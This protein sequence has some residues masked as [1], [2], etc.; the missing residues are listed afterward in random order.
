MT[1]DD[2]STETDA[3]NSELIAAIDIGTN[4]VHLVV[5]RT[6]GTSGYE[7]VTTQKEVVRLG[8]GSGDMKLLAPD[9]IDRGIAALSR[10]TDV[11]HSLGATV[12]AVATSAVREA[13][14]RNE[15]LDRARAEAGIEVE[16]ISGFEEARLI[17][18]GILK[19][20]P[21]FD[22]RIM[23]FDI[24]GGSTEIVAGEGSDLLAARSFR[25]GAI[26]L[27]ERF[28][29]DGDGANAEAVERCR[30]FVRQTLAGVRVEFVGH[31]PELLIASSGTAATL[32][33]M[34]AA[35]EALDPA[36]L[37]GATV[38][39]AQLDDLVELIIKTP[40][41][42]RGRIRGLDRKRSDIILGGAI[43][44]QQV[45]ELSGLDGFTYSALALRE[46][47]L[48]D[49]LPGAAADHLHNLRRA[50]VERLAEQLDPD[51]HHAKH[52]TTLALQLFDR[53]QSIHGL[54][55]ADRELLEMAG[56][57]H[58]VGLFI[59]HSGHHKHSYY[60][61]RNSE[62]LTGFSDREI[63]LIAQIARYHRKSHPSSGH[64]P[65]VELSEKDKGR[66]RT[67]AGL[68][69]I[70]I[71]LDRRHVGA[72]GTIR[73]LLG[74]AIEIEPL[75]SSDEVDLSVE[76]HAA[77]ERVSLLAEALQ[78]SVLVSLPSAVAIT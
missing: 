76:V 56:L 74:D 13:T 53:T 7:V 63:G 37:N 34:A 57:L 15:F 12:H 35:Q 8:S 58:N 6:L 59:S 18:L 4:S 19:A 66:V 26:R 68:L 47:V 54:L 2:R 38:T 45:V 49:R 70:A 42:K 21:V 5:A 27:T 65:F 17:H 61:I 22:K 73:V 52:C 23:A 41:A 40:P 43:L 16:V 29:T 67:L 72:V 75:P 31:Q 51:V 3:E 25:L 11:A 50:N 33:A 71:G 64:Q 10:M 69:R 48:V 77:M 44:A 32:T 78:C 60:V 20:L 1:E 62:Q 9:A 55:P 24:G 30:A 39:A 36:S 14:N 46:G 28:F